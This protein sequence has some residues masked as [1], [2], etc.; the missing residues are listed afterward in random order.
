MVTSESWMG[1][2]ITFL[3]RQ[4]HYR[5]SPSRTQLRRRGG[6]GGALSSI[7]AERMVGSGRDETANPF[8]VPKRRNDDGMRHVAPQAAVWTLTKT[9]AGA[10]FSKGR[11]QRPQT[12]RVNAH[13][14]GTRTM[15]IVGD[16]P[17]GS[18]LC[19]QGAISFFSL[20]PSSLGTLGPRVTKFGNQVKS[21]K[22]YPAPFHN[23]AAAFAVT[24]PR[25]LDSFTLFNTMQYC[26][27]LQSSSA[28]SIHNKS[29]RIASLENLVLS[30]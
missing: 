19:P 6:A 15:W 3:A 12:C 21:S 25:R 26:W 28:V 27:K 9:S 20:M 13:W 7:A 17:E 2:V 18:K 29:V 30:V 14:F 5:F 22:A 1:H 16:D 24:S 4:Q 8:D 10:K 11:L 23:S